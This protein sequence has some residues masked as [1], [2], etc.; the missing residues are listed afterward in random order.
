MANP[1]M[2]ALQGLLGSMGGPQE[3]AP[4][5]PMEPGMESP[6]PEMGAPSEDPMMHADALEAAAG[7]LAPEQQEMLMQGLSMIR[8]AL[9]SQTPAEDPLENPDGMG[10]VNDELV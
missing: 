1:R 3:P 2:N 10:E 6:M 9:G 8:Q 4:M 5:A 7:S